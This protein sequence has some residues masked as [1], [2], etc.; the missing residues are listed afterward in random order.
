LGKRKQ[1]LSLADKFG[2][3]SNVKA[4]KKGRKNYN[5]NKWK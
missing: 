1:E 5:E 3:D 2:E 4:V